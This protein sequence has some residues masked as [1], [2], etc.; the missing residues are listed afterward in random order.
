MFGRKPVIAQSNPAGK[1]D[2][3]SGAGRRDRYDPPLTSGRPLLFI[4]VR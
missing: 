1:M 3:K 2:K 4:K